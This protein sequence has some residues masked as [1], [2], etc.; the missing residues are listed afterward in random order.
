MTSFKTLL[1]LL[2]LAVL[3]LTPQPAP[4]IPPIDFSTAGFQ[5]GKPLPFV[6]ARIAVR[7]T[8]GDDTALLQSALDRLASLPIGVNGFRGALLLRPGRF[9][10]GGQLQLRASGVVLRG[11]GAGTDGTTIVA[12]GI[13]RRTLIEAG[14]SKPP[15]PGLARAITTE[16]V[17]AGA[18]SFAVADITGLAPGDHVV[19]TRPS[20]QA[21]IRDIVMTGLYGTFANTRIDWT[22]GS[23]NLVWD[24]VSTAVDTAAKSI[25]ADAP[26][27]TALEARYGGGSLARVQTGAPL[28]NIGIE[29]LTLDSVYDRRNA[30]DEE[31][32]WIAIAL[33]HV[34]DAWVRNVTARHFVSSAVR[35]GARARRVTI[36]D[37]RSESPVSEPAGYR[38]QAFLVYG[39]QVLVHRCHSQAGMNDFASGLLAAGPN[40]FLDC[41]AAGSLGASGAFEGWSSG[42]LYERVHIAGARLQ[43]VL[44]QSR[45][46]AA[47]WTA[48]NSILWNSTAISV[49]AIGPPGAP[50]FVV[51][52]PKSLYETQLAARGLRLA[53]APAKPIAEKLLP[54]FHEIA[55]HPEPQFI[56]HPFQVVNGRFVIDGKAVWGPTQ[57]ETWWRGNTSPAVAGQ[58][59]G[60]NISR[61]MPGQ[62]GPG[63]TEDLP[64]LAARLKSRGIL[65]YQ[66]IP[67]LWYEHRRDEHTVT[68]QTNAD[69]WAPFYEMPWA[70][71]GKGAAWDGLSL[72]DLSRYNL[73][74][75][76]RQRAF[77]RIAAANGLIV[78][79]HLYNNHNVLEIGPHW[80]DYPWRPANNVNDTGLPEPPPFK[81]DTR[82]I[83]PAARATVDMLRL[84]VGNQFYSAAYP[85]LRKLHH[86]YIF[87]VLDQLGDSPNVVFTVAYQYAGPLAFQQFFQDTVAE[88]EKQHNRRIRIALITSKQITDAILEDPIR[89]KQIAAVDMRYWQYLPDGTLWAPVAGENRA[90]REQIMV[91]FKGEFINSPPPTTPEL[92]Y[93][94]VR[95]Y[96]DHYPDIALLSMENGGGS[97]PVLMAGGASSLGRG[98]ASVDRFVHDYLASDLMKMNPQD[99]LVADP[100]QSWVLADD[101][102]GTVLIYS[103]AGRAITPSS[104]LPEGTYRALWFDPATAATRDIPS[105]PVRAGT[106]IEKPDAKDWLLLLR[107]GR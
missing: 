9:R 17:P 67:G 68:R 50:N 86:D 51:N 15:E 23:H 99:G 28:E 107:A 8:G 74:Y 25:T 78:I 12:E 26:I 35:A 30:S 34:E 79:H 53:A 3:P 20:T 102:S 52:S 37:C 76:E 43:L 66:T 97:L 18:T 45:A 60:S 32:A 13:G 71:T 21:W 42:V 36:E 47:G 89:S 91:R 106:P 40:V 77:A 88:W 59:T 10:V 87:H 33:D 72:F 84:D 70:R 63:L 1:I 22:P 94:Q 103:R 49:D 105:L 27:T 81:P 92:L 16:T 80:I 85:P 96:R 7:P 55:M 65:F 100:A 6:E 73:W 54:D 48:A 46:Q 4:A 93:R 64:E 11:S 69:A 39:Q 101:A 82:D 41:D 83:A 56:E 5:A 95:E 90:Y 62:V 61:F 98:S 2:P 14:G 19:I 58:L 104:H 38:R 44:D 24:R 57:A 75:F 31:H 29:N